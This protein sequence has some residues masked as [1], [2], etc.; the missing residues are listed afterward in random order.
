MPIHNTFT[1]IRHF[2][3]LPPKCLCHFLLKKRNAS[4]SNSCSFI[5]S[6]IHPHESHLVPDHLQIFQRFPAVCRRSNQKGHS[7]GE[8][9]GGI[10]CLEEKEPGQGHKSHL[11][12]WGRTTLHRALAV[13]KEVGFYSETGGKS[14][15]GFNQESAW[16]DPCFRKITSTTR[17]IGVFFFFFFYHFR[18]YW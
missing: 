6:F 5:H 3:A 17:N 7:T 11:G 15:E 8:S 10:V 14:V 13:C 12:K 1:N 16:S 18:L 4:F 2:K 9:E